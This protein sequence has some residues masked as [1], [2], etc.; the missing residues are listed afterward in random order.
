MVAGQVKQ[1]LQQHGHCDQVLHKESSTVGTVL[2]NHIKL[3]ALHPQHSSALH[4]PPSVV[5]R[6]LTLTSFSLSPRHLEMMVDA[7]GHK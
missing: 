3:Q 6:P 7:W 2:L 5:V 4:F 1:H